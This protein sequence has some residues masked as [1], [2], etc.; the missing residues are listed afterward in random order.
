MSAFV[1]LFF[2]ILFSL[3]AKALP[4]SAL[5]NSSEYQRFEQKLNLRDNLRWQHLLVCLAVGSVEDKLQE[6]IETGISKNYRIFEMTG[7]N[8][9]E[10]H[11]PESFSREGLVGLYSSTPDFNYY[12]MNIALILYGKDYDGSLQFESC[13]NV[14]DK[15]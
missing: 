5:I 10:G 7:K 6:E 4:F 12:M 8:K 13:G 15:M 14:T 1:N 3:T 2:V 11:V 9:V